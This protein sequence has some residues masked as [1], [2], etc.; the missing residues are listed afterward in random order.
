[1]TIA[2]KEQRDALL[3]IKQHEP[4]GWFPHGAPNHKMRSSLERYGWIARTR[5]SGSEVYKTI[6]SK[7]GMQQLS[8]AVKSTGR[9]HPFGRMKA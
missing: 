1:M 2:T 7:N 3:W 9:F 8:P 6:V 5:E 4:I